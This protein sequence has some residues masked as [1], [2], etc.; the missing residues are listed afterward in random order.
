MKKFLLFLLLAT[1]LTNKSSLAYDI[2]VDLDS[3]PLNN[4]ECTC[5]DII[6][7]RL[8]N[9]VVSYQQMVQDLKD[10]LQD[11]EKKLNKEDLLKIIEFHQKDAEFW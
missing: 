11:D 3:I 7:D 10:I 4:N 2:P 9:K 8:E 5:V 1:F 6:V